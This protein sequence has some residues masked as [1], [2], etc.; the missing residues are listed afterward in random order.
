MSNEK[1]QY[2]YIYLHVF[3]N[4][5]VYVGQTWSCP[6]IRWGHGGIGY[7]SQPKMW[8]AIEKYGWNNILHI[9]REEGYFSQQEL[10]NREKFWVTYYDTHN[11]G[12]NATDGGDTSHW[13]NRAVYQLDRETFVIINTYDSVAKAAASVSIDSSSIVACCERYNR[14][15]RGFC[16]CYAEDY[17][18]GWTPNLEKADY[19]PRV[20]CF[21]TDTIYENTTAASKATGVPVKN[22]TRICYQGDYRY[23]SSGGYHFCYYLNKDK[24]DIEKLFTP[25][26]KRPIMCIDTGEQF[27]SIAEAGRQTG[28][29]VSSIQKCVLGQ[30]PYAG[31]KQWCYLTKKERK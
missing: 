6:T 27:Q 21:E 24:I 25:G 14:T 10:N 29:C 31:G 22:I 16:W 15:C 11:F 7:K 19:R 12:Y 17:K 2:G 4:G 23:K 28:V 9:I 8:N 30:R 5:K 3:P 26:D 1:V 13:K 20:Y 18:E